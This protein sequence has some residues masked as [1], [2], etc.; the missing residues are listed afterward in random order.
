[1]LS[2]SF[3][4][5]FLVIRPNKH[6]K[7]GWCY[8]LIFCHIYFT[9]WNRRI[10]IIVKTKCFKY[11]SSDFVI[12]RLHAGVCIRTLAPWFIYFLKPDREPCQFLTETEKFLAFFFVV[13]SSFSPDIFVRYE[14][15]RIGY[16]LCLHYY[17]SSSAIYALLTNESTLYKLLAAVDSR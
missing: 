6:A 7:F 10:P 15:Q 11:F 17:T 16:I 12:R 5:S 9:T 2:T 14:F 4:A 1:M 3:C 13:V 8:L